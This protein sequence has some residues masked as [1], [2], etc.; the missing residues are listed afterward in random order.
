M[1][2][3]RVISRA[4]DDLEGELSATALVF[5]LD[6]H[7]TKEMEVLSL[8]MLGTLGSS[9]DYLNSVLEACES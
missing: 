6:K 4:A 2:L 7:E 3:K 8:E 5:Y 1:L 9:F